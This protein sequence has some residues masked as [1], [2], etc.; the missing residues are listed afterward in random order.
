MAPAAA[1]PRYYLYALP[2][3]TVIDASGL[4]ANTEPKAMSAT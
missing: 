1:L 3:M 4:L 2:G